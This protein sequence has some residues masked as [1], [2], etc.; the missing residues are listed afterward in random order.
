GGGHPRLGGQGEGNTRKA[1]DGDGERP[2]PCGSSGR[3]RNTFADGARHGRAHRPSSYGGIPPP[4]QCS[5]HFQAP[6]VPQRQTSLTSDPSMITPH[7]WVVYS[8]GSPS[9]RTRSP[10]FPT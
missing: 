1:E 3:G 9:K 7:T 5:L 10:S 4:H 6:G 8:K 2:H